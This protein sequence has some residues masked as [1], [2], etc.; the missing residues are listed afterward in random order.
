MRSF[1]S[2]QGIEPW[3]QPTAPHHGLRRYLETLRERWWVVALAVIV[4]TA[5]AASYVALATPVYEARG[6]LLVT[7]VSEGDDSATPGLGL[8]RES[9]DPTR[10]VSTVAAFVTTVPVARRV[11]K[12][13][14]TNQE[15]AELLDYVTAEP[16]A[17]TSIV[18]VK[19]EAATPDRAAAIANAFMVETVRL[20]TEQLRAQL[21]RTI[22]KLN[23]RLQT[24]SSGDVRDAL[25]QEIGTLEALQGVPDPTVRV[26]TDATPSSEP[27]SPKTGLSLAAGVLAGL[28]LGSG[29]AFGLQ[30][31]DPRLR[32]E[33]QI[34]ELYRL[35]VLARIPSEG[36]SRRLGVLSPD[37]LSRSTT[38]A[39]RT[40][41]AMIAAS[42]RGDAKP[43][44]IL[45]TGS[46]PSEGKTTTAINLAYEMVQAGNSV[47][48]IEA[49]THAPKI[50]VSLGCRPRYGL[51]SVLIR[52]VTLEDALVTTEAYGPDLRLLLVDRPGL[53][54]ADRLSLPTA[55][56][57]L[58]EAERL[59]DYVVIDS[60]PLTEVADALPLAQEVDD[61][62]IVARLGHSSMTKLAV[63]GERLAQQGVHP[64]GLVLVGV[65]NESADYYYGA[66]R[67]EK[68]RTERSSATSRLGERPST[69]N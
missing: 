31:L 23:G 55:L 58:S 12:R 21:D 38:E 67:A 26:L 18:T 32:R 1:P 65:K 62:L 19:G 17:Q 40:L 48:L 45:V 57:L 22:G 7:P 24:L 3:L 30:A 56:L 51:G 37:R 63:L 27:T 10:G 42:Y 34:H 53:A 44:S 5:A 2:H 20:R 50:G 35:P 6:N 15:P 16:F 25:T 46:S 64:L 54:T 60:P 61:T 8:I 14:R 9:N 29:G 47:I 41:R 52:E 49:D 66:S 13:I 69:V 33:E 4:C 28:I 11:A 43:R 59:A 68:T 39:Y 36:R